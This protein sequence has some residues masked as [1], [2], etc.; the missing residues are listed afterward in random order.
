MIEL[1]NV[2]NS[3]PYK[4]FSEYYYNAIKKKQSSIEAISVSSFNPVK[5][6]VESRFV[7][8]KYIIDDQWIFFTNYDSRKGKDFKLHDQVSVL[9]FWNSIN[10]QIR[11]KAK[12]K[13]TSRQFSDKH[14]NNRAKDKNV[15]AVSS[16][17]S[18]LIDSYDSVV[19]NYENTLSR[20]SSLTRPEYWGGYAF[21]PYYFEFW[22]GHKSRI[23]KRTAYDLQQNNWN[24]FIL[25]P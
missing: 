20:K 12:I 16:D 24:S 22:E 8:I 21:I 1:I 18:K 19:R 14:F 15:L 3:E 5:K 13:Q 11:I 2:N 4:I 6:E 7:N 10:L 9:F 23:N 25:Q 17:Q